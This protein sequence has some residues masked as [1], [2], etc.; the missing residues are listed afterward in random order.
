VAIKVALYHRTPH[1]LP[2]WQIVYKQSE[3]WI[4]TAAF[5]SL[6]HDLRAVLRTAEGGKE[7]PATAI[8]DYKTQQEIAH[9]ATDCGAIVPFV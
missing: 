5:D 4:K 1:D 6:A 3:R 2:P 7:S 8:E 9:P